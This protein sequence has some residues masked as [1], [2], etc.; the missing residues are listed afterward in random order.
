MSTWALR[1]GCLLLMLG[2]AVIMATAADRVVPLNLA[3]QHEP[4]EK[5]RITEIARGEYEWSLP[6][7]VGQSLLV[8]LK[9][10]GVT[11][12]DYDEFRFD[13]KP[14][15]SEVDLH[16]VLFGMPTET[17]FASWYLKFKIATGQWSTGRFDLRVDD[18]GA[19]KRDKGQS[20]TLRLDLSRRV[21]GVPGEPQWRKVRFRNPRF[22]KWVVA[23]EFEP[24]D[25]KIITD[26]KVVS[27]TYGL[28]VKNRTD[29]PLTARIEIDPDQSL[30]EFKARPA[31]TIGIELAAGEEKV[32]PIILALGAK[33][34]KELPPA[35]AERICPKVWVEGVADSEVSPLQ[36]YRS[37]LMWA[38]APV[39]NPG[40]TPATMQ[41]RVAE[42]GKYMPV[43]SWKGRILNEANET[44]KYDWPVTDWVRADADPLTVPHFGQDYRCPECKSMDHMRRDPPNSLTRHYCGKCNKLFEN[45]AFLNTV[46]MEENFAAC[47]RRIRGLALA[48]Q[49][50]GK[51]QYA[52][53]AIAMALDWAAAQPT[54]TVTGYRSCG[55]GTR[56]A[57]NTL[58]TSWCLPDLAEAR[59]L[60]ATYPGLTSEKR[61]KWDTMLIDEG[62]RVTRQCGLW[63]N[64]QDEYIK[65]GTTVA[66][67]TGYWPLLGEAIHGDF[68]WHA[69]IEHG[70]TE[71][72]I[73]HEGLAYHRMKFGC[74]QS[75]AGVAAS[76]GIDLMTP[77]I[78]RIFDGTLNLG[79]NVS[80]GYELAYRAYREPNYLPGLEGIRK[81]PGEASILYGVLPLP[82]AGEAK[83]ASV[84]M[85]GSGYIMLRRGSPLDSWEIRLNYKAQLD[86][87]EAD[88]Y[89]TWFYRSNRQVD[90]GI[91]RRRYSSPGAVFQEAT[92]AHNTIVIDGQNSRDV[93]GQL[94][95]YQGEGDTPFAV[96]QT[97][98]TATLFAGVRQLR[99]IAILGDAYV[100]FDRVVCDT[101]CTI[102]RYQYAGPA[103]LKFAAAAPAT[104][105]TKLN[106][107]GRFTDVLTGAAGKEMRID[108]GGGL[109]MRLVCDQEMTGGKARTPTEPN[110]T[111]DVT[112][113]RVD[114]ARGATFLATFSLGQDTEPPAVKIVKSADDE[115]IL[116]VQGKGK[117]YTMTV[118]PTEKKVVVE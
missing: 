46:V 9:K 8:D 18:D 3:T 99:G 113:A 49:L 56:L 7:G 53:K 109:K 4:N 63:L 76:C 55:L 11:P 52:D 100:V 23:T 51:A 37:M 21:L 82:P 88:R 54:F 65:V 44:L 33:R 107:K 101:P 59:A 117:T 38:V 25:V 95:A 84:H 31:G 110:E 14:L 96:V 50:T 73:G 72:G 91:G 111:M 78:K 45:D 15:G 29:T 87:G 102:D 57:A 74:L 26:D 69:Q 17:E 98:P 92:A 6:D 97:D 103:N 77:R 104:P 39:T 19:Y 58:C 16:T 79:E 75:T 106:E 86:R 90:S 48:W 43:D 22:I 71:E 41:T 12:R 32:V 66:M 85:E 112:W 70:F 5:L 20:G 28:K 2:G 89:S 114:N 80:P 116:E 1:W 118:K 35:Y 24:R 68:G 40:W 42:A 13:I 36:G 61:Q 34:A 10:L 115:L 105:L 108:F 94:V 93:I 27:Y 60:L 47:F 83:L 67:A 64:Q 81:I 62:L 30:K